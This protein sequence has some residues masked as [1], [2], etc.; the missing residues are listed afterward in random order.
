MK[1]HTPLLMQGGME[2]HITGNQDQILNYSA[3]NPD[4]VIIFSC[5]SHSNN[6]G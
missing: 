2:F 5:F 3:Q 1:F 4:S 6:R